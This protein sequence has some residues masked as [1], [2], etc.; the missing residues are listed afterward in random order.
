MT[1]GTSHAPHVES[2]VD[3][4]SWC[5]RPGQSLRP[6]FLLCPI[7]V[8]HFSLEPRLAANSDHTAGFPNNHD[9]F[10]PRRGSYPE[11]SPRRSNIRVSEAPAGRS[12]YFTTSRRNNSPPPS[13]WP[14]THGASGSAN[15]APARRSCC[16]SCTPTPHCKARHRPNRLLKNYLRCHCCVKNRLVRESDQNAHLQLVKSSATPTVFRLF[17]WGRHRYCIGCLAYVFQRPARRE[18]SRRGMAIASPGC[19]HRTSP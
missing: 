15:R 19:D 3:M 10:A 17:L 1:M 5:L 8:D 18:A 12:A 4:I 16:W 14:A 7:A 2:R 6:I 11:R 9:R 13:R